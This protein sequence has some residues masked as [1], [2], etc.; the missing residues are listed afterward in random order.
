MF[1]HGA[2][3][4][5]DSGQDF[6]EATLTKCNG[7]LVGVFWI[8]DLLQNPSALQPEV[9]NRWLDIHH[10]HC[11]YVVPWYEMLCYFYARCD[12]T[13]TLQKV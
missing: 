10:M 1:Y 9:T 12:G 11:W 2:A 7:G 5:S 6:D 3:S 13:H 4:L 8:I